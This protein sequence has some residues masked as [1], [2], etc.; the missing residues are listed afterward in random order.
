MAGPEL[1][2]QFVWDRIGGQISFPARV[3]ILGPVSGLA[4]KFNPCHRSATSNDKIILQ[5]KFAIVKRNLRCG[6]VNYNGHLELNRRP[7][8]ASR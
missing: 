7:E 6:K 5:N 4:P 1:S 2:G 3:G 8:S